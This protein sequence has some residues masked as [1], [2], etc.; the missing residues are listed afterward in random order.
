VW[1]RISCDPAAIQQG[2]EHRSRGTPIIVNCYHTT[3]EDFE[4][5]VCAAVQQWFSTFVR[6]QPGNFFF[7]IRQGSGIID[8]RAQ[9]RAVAQWL[10]NTAVQ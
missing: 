1:L 2:C 4:D 3:S 7:S 8:A 6:P 9:Y 10:R 5:F